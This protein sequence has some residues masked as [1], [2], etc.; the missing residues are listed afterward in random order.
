LPI[1][2][3]LKSEQPNLAICLALVVFLSVFTLFCSFRK[4]IIFL[5]AVDAFI[6]IW[7]VKLLDIAHFEDDVRGQ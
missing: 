3:N 1:A 2:T 7:I 4:L 6:V 5:V